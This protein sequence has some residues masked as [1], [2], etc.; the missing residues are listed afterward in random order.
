MKTVTLA[1]CALALPLLAGCVYVGH[2]NQIA[3]CEMYDRSERSE[4][5]KQLKSDDHLY[6][7]NRKM[8]PTYGRVPSEQDGPIKPIIIRYSEA[9]NL[10]SQ[11][12]L[13]LALNTVREVKRD[14]IVLVFVHGWRNDSGLKNNL[15]YNY[16]D[17][18]IPPNVMGG[19][20]AAFTALATSVSKR[21]NRPVIPIYISWKAGLGLGPLE[22]ITFWSRRDA[23]DRIARTG[24]LNR[25]F[26]AIENISDDQEGIDKDGRP[27]IASEDGRPRIDNQVIYMGHSFGSRILFSSIVVE[28]ISRAQLAYPETGD[29]DGLQYAEIKPPADLIL[30][31]NP[32]LE[33]AS[34]RAVDEFRYSAA[35]FENNKLPLMLVMQSES[36]KAVGAYFPIGQFFWA[37]LNATRTTGLG[38]KPEYRT[39]VMCVKTAGVA[40]CR[41]HP[42]DDRFL[43]P[44]AGC[45][46]E[47]Y[48]FATAPDVDFNNDGEPDAVVD[49][50]PFDV[51]VVD[52]E[53]LDGHVW[54]SGGGGVENLF[55]NDKQ[56]AARFDDWLANLLARV[57]RVRAQESETTTVR[58]SPALALSPPPTN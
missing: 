11:C 41:E 37:F 3:S 56:E 53:I 27:R 6:D 44:D 20:L 13:E 39:H 55:S 8:A 30:L 46:A 10:V 58:P 34:Y 28:M 49:D 24:E 42:A 5:R 14:K 12:D 26:S 54:F 17:E 50:T 45:A 40:G 23:A 25:L 29:G 38:F 15:I 47:P 35:K 2:T 48:A 43:C 19:D 21:S 16:Q 4:I 52:E 57:S 36:D 22:T 32:A 7:L 33:A 1:L 31:F 9:G 18:A 51:V